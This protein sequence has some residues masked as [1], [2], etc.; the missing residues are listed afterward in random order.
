M[1]I[2]KQFAK[3]SSSLDQYFQEISRLDLIDQE[4]E[5]LLAQKIRQG[6]K[7][8]LNS[9]VEANLRF[10]ISV[11]KQFQNQ[12]LSL[13]DLINEG[14]VGLI[15]AA[16]RF[17]ETKG[18]KFV[19]YAVWWIR[20]SILEAITS[21]SR[22]VRLPMNKVT[23]VGKIRKAYAELEQ[24]NANTP[25]LVELS[26]KLKMDIEDVAQALGAIRYEISIDAPISDGEDTLLVDV[27]KNE[28][29]AS[30]DFDLMKESLKFHLEK[31]LSSLTKRESDVIKLYF[32]IDNEISLTLEE[33]GD[34]YN[35]TKERVRQIKEKAIRNLRRVADTN[36]L[37]D[38][39]K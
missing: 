27:I 25:S 33:I 24:Q 12:G 16:K 30:P 36:D 21:Q 7:K 28:N 37:R 9:L 38:Y 22:I 10:V 5:I 26:K 1:I 17:D 39:L 35:L 23:E 3:P 11:A 15:K 18:F 2:K 8:A 34:R 20:Q 14:N 13:D 32:G 6:D 4:E 19:S 29:V 31:V